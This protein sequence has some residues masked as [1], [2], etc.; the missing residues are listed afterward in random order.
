[1]SLPVRDLSYPGITSGQALSILPRLVAANPQMVVIE[2]G[3]HDYLKGLGRT[4]TRQNLEK[5]VDAARSIG[6]EVILMEIPRG[7]IIDEFDGL[8]RQMARQEALELVPDTA[9]RKLVLW[10]PAAPP[11]MWVRPEHRL[12]DDG[13]H[14]NAR[15]N[16]VLAEYVADAL[17][18]IYGPAVRANP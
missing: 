4:A 10:S 14:P 9:I 16:R 1:M 12:S 11:G 3:G 8:E 13:L 5:I 6:A 18:R 2:L 15:G 17:E 7:F